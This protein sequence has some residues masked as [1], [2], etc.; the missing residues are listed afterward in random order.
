MR[1]LIKRRSVRALL[2]VVFFALI[3]SI[4][5]ALAP[6]PQGSCSAMPCYEVEH[7][8]YSDASYTT[9]VGYKYVSCNGIYTWGTVT[10]YRISYQGGCCGSC[11]DPK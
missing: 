2:T 8:Y 10:V 3:L 1:T 4:S 7:E 9:Q 11:C 6:S 5:V